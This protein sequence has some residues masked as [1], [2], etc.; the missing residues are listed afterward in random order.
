M[1]LR[2]GLA[3]TVFSSMKTTLTLKAELSVNA[4]KNMWRAA[5]TVTLGNRVRNSDRLICPRLPI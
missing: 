2:G 5:S 4:G 1:F 3:V